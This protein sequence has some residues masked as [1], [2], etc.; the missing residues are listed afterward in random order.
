M[1]TNQRVFPSE[2]ITKLKH[3]DKFSA[4][5]NY[6]P[7]RNFSF[8]ADLSLK[9]AEQFLAENANYTLFSQGLI[10]GKNKFSM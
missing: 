1:K 5:F 10:F 7:R 6:F 4:I 9:D 3:L 2:A 8:S